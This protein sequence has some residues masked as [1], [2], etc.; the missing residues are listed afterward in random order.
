M[1]LLLAKLPG[2]GVDLERS[3]VHVARCDAGR[4]LAIALVIEGLYAV[5]QFRI[6]PCNQAAAGLVRKSGAF[7]LV[8]V[9]P[10]TS[11][12]RLLATYQL[13]TRDRGSSLKPS[14]QR[15]QT[16]HFVPNKAGELL[17]SQA[18]SGNILFTNLPVDEHEP[19]PVFMFGSHAGAT[20]ITSGASPFPV[21]T[22]CS[23]AVSAT[24]EWRIVGI[25]PHCRHASFLPTP[26]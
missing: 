5:S 16:F 4:S 14:Q 18:T 25:R 20:C 21:H 7:Q 22:S 26:S 1:S 15:W 17:L 11:T 23:Q 6:D 3:D 13:C 10:G 12:S 2:L 9:H 8:A 24:T 19:S